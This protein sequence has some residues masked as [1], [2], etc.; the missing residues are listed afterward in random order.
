MP[1]DYMEVAA[2]FQF[3]YP[4]IMQEITISLIL[5]TYNEAGNIE[6]AIRRAKTA[7]A[8]ISHEIIVADDDS[9][10]KTWEAA[11]K[12]FEG[13]ATVKV[14]RR[15]ENRGLY[16]AVIEGFRAASGKYL[17]VMD[18]DLQHDESILPKLLE[19]AQQRGVTLAIGSRYVD[20]GGIGKWNAVR[21]AMSRTG[22]KTAAIIIG[23]DIKDLMSGFFLIERAAFYNV[24]P[25][26]QPKGFK[27]LMDIACRL[28]KE[29]KVEEV[30]FTFRKREVG[31]SKLDSRVAA[32]FAQALYELS[33][34]G[35]FN[36][37]AFL[38]I[39]R[40]GL[41]FLGASIALYIAA[42]F[43]AGPGASMAVATAVAAAVSYPIDWLRANGFGRGG[44]RGWYGI[45]GL[46]V[47]MAGIVVFLWIALVLGI[48]LEWR[49]LAVLIA[50]AAQSGVETLFYLGIDKA[51]SQKVS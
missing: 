28:P 3:G 36:T 11:A 2:R 42:K 23:R 49:Y 30:P 43:D 45:W 34:I 41:A 15:T 18:A 29:A 32:Q 24:L 13:D 26:L 1:R 33:P 14:I 17:A 16:P 51:R 8:G 7:L 27:I 9:P 5:P 31:E 39:L 47:K 50:A 37:M 22:N 19:A 10:D 21:K 40:A 4:R 25:K 12:V 48:R 20:G 46:G 6:N 35:G 38:T 44:K